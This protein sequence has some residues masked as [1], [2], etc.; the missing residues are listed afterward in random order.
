VDAKDPYTCGHSER[1]ALIAQHLSRHLHLAED[2]INNIYLAGLLHDVGKIGVDEAVL[3]K[4]GRLTDIEFAQVKKHPQ[5][6]ADILRPIRQMESVTQAVLAHH[7]RFDGGGYPHGLAGRKIPLTGRIMMLADSF[8]AMVS[9]RTYRRALPV[10]AALA[11][12]RRFSGTQ[13]DP[14]LADIFM[15]SD[16]PSLVTRMS[17][18]SRQDGAL[19]IPGPTLQNLYLPVLN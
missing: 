7:E 18:V 13:F 3:C 10:E 14:E 15:D 8:D 2:Q 19:S 11:E 4:P 5:I 6:G 12:I 9:D 1:V 16:I 17:N